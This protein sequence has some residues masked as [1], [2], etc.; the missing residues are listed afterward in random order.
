MEEKIE[1]PGEFLFRCSLENYVM[2]QRI[3]DGRFSGWINISPHVV[4]GP[5]CWRRSSYS[6]A[7]FVQ[8]LQVECTITS[9]CLVCRCVCRHKPHLVKG[10]L[11]KC[12][13]IDFHNRRCLMILI[14]FG[15]STKNMQ[16]SWILGTSTGWPQRSLKCGVCSPSVRMRSGCWWRGIGKWSMK[17]GSVT[18]LPPSRAQSGRP[19]PCR[20]CDSHGDF[21]S[22]TVGCRPESQ[23]VP[24]TSRCC[25][26]TVFR[27]SR[28][29]FIS[30][31]PQCTGWG[32]FE[33]CR[34]EAGR[35]RKKH[36][37]ADGAPRRRARFDEVVRR[38]HRT[39]RWMCDHGAS[40]AAAK[41]QTVATYIRR[42]GS[43][44]KQRRNESIEAVPNK[45]PQVLSPDQG[46]EF[47]WL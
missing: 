18:N 3:G 34:R 37:P 4:S 26:I 9:W 20:S 31:N 45:A 35:S 27:D 5:Q 33:A 43:R 14:H 40:S 23:F 12:G 38:L 46:A 41:A 29:A 6:V 32:R 44:A 47:L 25:S 21:S 7:V 22:V 17:A 8:I 2:D 16:D 39:T 13:R 24:S 36:G 15:S 19:K 28:R 11:H 1:N 42:S 30:D 10:L